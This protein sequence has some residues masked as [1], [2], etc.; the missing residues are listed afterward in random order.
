MT[1]NKVYLYNVAYSQQTLEGIEAGYLILD[2]LD[3]ERPDW[4]EYWPIRRFLL[5]HTL[6]EDAFYGFFSP[7]FGSKTSLTYEQTLRHVTDSA[8]GT[9]VVLF[10][11]QP[12]MGA[13]FLNVFEQGETFDPGFIKAFENFLE[14]IDLKVEL[15]N[16]VMDSRQIVF[17]NYFVARAAFW[18]AWFEITEKFFDV[19]EGTVCPLQ[20]DLTQSTTYEGGV[21]RKVFLLERVASFLL[22]T[23]P[24]WRSVAVDPFSFGWSMSKFREY[25]DEAII[26]DALK[27]AFREQKYSEYMEVYARLRQRCFRGGS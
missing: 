17:S 16:I 20:Q 21:Q 26:S 23:Q 22:I 3:N 10:S 11:P 14:Q 4:R 27:L 7:K 1:N 25:P 13:F 6:E 8:P 2:N 5:T 18:R 12:D 24:K 9:D 15:R 19:C